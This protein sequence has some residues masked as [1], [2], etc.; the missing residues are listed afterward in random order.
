MRILVKRGGTW[1]AWDAVV[2]DHGDPSQV[3]A[4]ACD[5]H[6]P[7]EAEGANGPPELSSCFARIEDGYLGPAA[8]ELEDPL[9]FDDLVLSWMADHGDDMSKVVAGLVHFMETHSLSRLS[10][11]ESARDKRPESTRASIRQVIEETDCADVV[12]AGG[13]LWFDY[14]EVLE[15][16]L[17]EPRRTSA[18]NACLEDLAGLRPDDLEAVDDPF[19]NSEILRQFDEAIEERTFAGEAIPQALWFDRLEKEPEPS[20]ELLELTDRRL[21]ERFPMDHEVIKRRLEHDRRISSANL[22]LLKYKFSADHFEDPQLSREVFDY[23]GM[24]PHRDGLDEALINALSEGQPGLGMPTTF[25]QRIAKLDAYPRSSSNMERL[26][27]VLVSRSDALAGEAIAFVESAG[28]SR[29]QALLARLDGQFAEEFPRGGE[30][31]LKRLNHDSLT[32]PTPAVRDAVLERAREFKERGEEV[33][34]EACQSVRLLNSMS[35][36][37]GR[38]T[39]P[40]NL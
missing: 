5:E 22:E 39:L 10:T 12:E 13:N 20:Q 18:V 15:E 34:H 7:P 1:Q 6:R 21:L 23:P 30:F 25:K 31:F 40:D 33:N 9:F 29:A 16:A 8:R 19:R 11:W 36:A 4:V 32:R 14:I 27:D 17:D 26:M 28:E 2:T 37:S 35:P 38:C 24:E 3:R